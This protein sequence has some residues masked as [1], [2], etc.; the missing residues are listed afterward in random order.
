MPVAVSNLAAEDPRQLAGRVC[1][2]W[3][4]GPSPRSAGGRDREVHVTVVDDRRIRALNTRYL[5]IRRA[6]DVLAF[7]L[8]GPGPGRLWG[9]VIVSVET[10]ARQARRLGVPLAT[11]LDLLVVHGTAAPGRL[12]RSRAAPGPPDARAGARDPGRPVAARDPR[13]ALGRAPRGLMASPHRA[14]F[15]ALVGRPNVGKSTLLNR[16]VGEKMAIVSPRPQTTRTRITG[17]RHLPGAQIVFVDT[18]GPARGGGAP[19]PAH[20]AGGRPRGGGRRPRL[21]RG[22]G[23]R[24]PDAPR[25]RRA[26]TGSRPAGPRSTAAST[27]PTWSARSRACCRSSRPIACAYPFAEI[28]PLSARARRALRPRC[29]T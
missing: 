21:L 29:S 1:A 26:S 8:A 7:D 2:R 24:G 22:G 19:R 15:V 16:L 4:A 17:I 13:A 6:T 28:V 3:P 11:E 10:A 25:P 9:E 12:R 27:R 5:G 23:D 18:P 20:V 14:G